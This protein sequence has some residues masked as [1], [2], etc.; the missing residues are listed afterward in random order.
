LSELDPLF[1][2][3]LEGVLGTSEPDPLAG[4]MVMSISEEL[5]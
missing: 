3:E 2:S 1:N 5:N 4:R